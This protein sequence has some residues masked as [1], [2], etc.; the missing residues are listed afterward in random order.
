MPLYTEYN[1]AGESK[2]R[3]NQTQEKL[4]LY[5]LRHTQAFITISMRAKIIFWGDV[6]TELRHD[7]SSATVSGA[8]SES[9]PAFSSSAS[10]RPAS[11]KKYILQVRGNG[12]HLQHVGWQQT[13]T[14]VQANKDTQAGRCR[15]LSRSTGSP[16]PC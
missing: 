15:A 9:T 11:H 16:S 2:E 12:D 6:Q 4:K 1:A 3:E 7:S 13:V 14:G 10:N 8:V 5:E